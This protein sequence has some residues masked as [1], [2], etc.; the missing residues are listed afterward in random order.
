VAGIVELTQRLRCAVAESKPGPDAIGAI[1]RAYFAFTDE[2]PAVYQAMF[3]LTTGL[4]FATDE[5]PMPLKE[6]FTEL[7]KVLSPA[8]GDLGSLTEVFWST[9]HGIAVL[10]ANGRMRPEHQE[11]RVSIVI[12]L[13]G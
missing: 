10:L 1:A 11:H 9:L 4:A 7:S 8:N 6:S 13:F 2:H 5:A 12:N 3:T